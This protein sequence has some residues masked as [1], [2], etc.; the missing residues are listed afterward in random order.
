MFE[1]IAL[2]IIQGFTEFLP[3]SSSAHLIILPW[4][5]GWK[6]VVDTIT[7]DVALH[8]G[9]T[10]ALLI[11]FRHDWIETLR[12]AS[13]KDAMMWKLL[14]GTIPVGVIGF[15]FHD[16]FEKT[17]SPLLIVFTLCLVSVFM[18]LSER[19][20]KKS[21]HAGIENVRLFDAIFI[22]FAQALALVPGVSRSG[23]TIVAGL[24]RGLRRDAS[25]RFSFLLGTPAILG[26]SILEA[27]NLTK[28]DNIDYSIFI[29]GVLVSAITGYI[30][31]RFLLSFFQR[32]SLIPFAYYRFFLASVIILS[33]WRGLAG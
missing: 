3:V 31:I 33:I 22:G 5:F 29:A 8:A 21:Q 9:T 27:R 16:L 24:S 23:I 6:G 18:I 1:A 30:A 32:H 10:L 25:A 12:T 14:V 2:G 13:R 4:F 26:A 17:R 11:Y 19:S 7:F 20:Y 15:L 28:V